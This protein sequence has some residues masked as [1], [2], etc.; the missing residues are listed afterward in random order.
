LAERRGQGGWGLGGWGA[1][2]PGVVLEGGARSFVAHD[3]LV[4]ASGAADGL[5][6]LGRRADHLVPLDLGHLH[7]QGLEFRV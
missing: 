1:G 6:A 2:A 7:V 4:D 3:E 5:L